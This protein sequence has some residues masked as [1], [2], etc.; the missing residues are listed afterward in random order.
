MS[1]PGGSYKVSGCGFKT[2]EYVPSD[3][4]YD[5]GVMIYLFIFET[6]LQANKIKQ[7]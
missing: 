4:W 5:E 6:V 1:R 2:G 3:A 7:K